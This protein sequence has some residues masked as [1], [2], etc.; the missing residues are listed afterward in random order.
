MT[1]GV[2]TLTEQKSPTGLNPN[3]EDRPVG[4]LL[5]KLR[6]KAASHSFQSAPVFADVPLKYTET[7]H[8][9]NEEK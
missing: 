9:A 1:E 6:Y 4:D 8:S 3:I 7:K 5:L 2:N